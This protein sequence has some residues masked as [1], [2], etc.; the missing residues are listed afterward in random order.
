MELS[1]EV[2]RTREEAAAR[3]IQTVRNALDVDDLQYDDKLSASDVDGWD[4]LSHIRLLVSVEKEFHFRFTSGEV[5]GLKNLGEML[6]IVMQ[7]GAA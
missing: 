4:S 5:D 2:A 1:E 7:R 3:L 6:D